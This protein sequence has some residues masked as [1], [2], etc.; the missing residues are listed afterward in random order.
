MKKQN[1]SLLWTVVFYLTVSTISV[2]AKTLYRKN[3]NVEATI[4]DG[5]GGTVENEL[6]SMDSEDHSSDY[7]SIM[8]NDE[9]EMCF[10][11]SYEC[12]YFELLSSAQ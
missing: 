12:V 2:T 7:I 9:E 8:G 11:G 5:N 3:R 6:I 1:V 10:K 4:T